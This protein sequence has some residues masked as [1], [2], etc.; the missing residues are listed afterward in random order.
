MRQNCLQHFVTKILHCHRHH[1]YHIFCSLI[2]KNYQCELCLEFV[3]IGNSM[4]Y[5]AVYKHVTV[6]CTKN[7]QKSILKTLDTFKEKSSR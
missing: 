6:M 4:F 1:N 2:N 5:S 3:L 7:K